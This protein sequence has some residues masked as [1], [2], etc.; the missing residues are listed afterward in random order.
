MY[1]SIAIALCGLVFL[2][3]PVAALVCN[4]AMVVEVFGFSSW[5]G[6]CIN[7]VLVLNILIAVALT[8]KFTAHIGRAFVL[9]FVSSEDRK[10]SIA[11]P[12]SDGCQISIKW[13]TVCMCC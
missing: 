9:S 1:V 11:L 10:R 8:M 2:L 13:R 12:G 5:L 7:G 4:T 6:L 3:N